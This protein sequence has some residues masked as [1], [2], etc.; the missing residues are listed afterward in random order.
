MNREQAIKLM[1]DQFNAGNRDLASQAGMSE[2]EINKK[3]EEGSQAI[4]HLLTLVYD[5][6]N[7]N[8]LLK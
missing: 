5:A 6:M 7:V 1:E 3:L 8:G 4:N 2:E